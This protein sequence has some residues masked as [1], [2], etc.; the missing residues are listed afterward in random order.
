MNKPENKSKNQDNWERNMWY[1]ILAALV[2]L[3]LVLLWLLWRKGE[4]EEPEKTIQEKASDTLSPE[5]LSPREITIDKKH[6]GEQAS[7]QKEAKPV[8]AVKTRSPRTKKEQEAPSKEIAEQEAPAKKS[9]RV[10]KP[11]QK[12]ATVETKAPEAP[13]QEP[14]KEPTVDDFTRIQGIGPKINNL[15]HEQG[16]LTYKQLADEKP[17]RLK[18]ILVDASL[19]GA[20]PTTWPEQAA[21]A[22]AGDW[23]AIE[24]L[25]N[26]I[27][28]SRN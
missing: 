25:K 18:N 6:P 16:I 4:E 17:L 10:S 12:A 27:K 5:P 26:K 20:N 7:I 24:E 3:L 23:E 9:T 22:D 1:Y 13:A 28:G 19:F 2:P 21:F 15:F 14:A 8:A 11:R